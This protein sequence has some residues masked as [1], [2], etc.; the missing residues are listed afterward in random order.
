MIS[1]NMLI[2]LDEERVLFISLEYR[3]ERTTL[4]RKE[5]NKMIVT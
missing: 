1:Q 4:T 5:T 2:L 3:T